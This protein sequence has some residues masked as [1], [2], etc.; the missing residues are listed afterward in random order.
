MSKQTV[1]G[2]VRDQ[3][4]GHPME[5]QNTQAVYEAPE[6]MEAGD[7]ADLTLGGFGPDIETFTIFGLL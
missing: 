7:F 2:T 4:K 5:E 6:L 3:R 1:D